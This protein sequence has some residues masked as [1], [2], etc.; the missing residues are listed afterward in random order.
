M[1]MEQAGPAVD[2]AGVDRVGRAAPGAAQCARRDGRDCQGLRQGTL[3]HHGSVGHGTVAARGVHPIALDH[4]L[5]VTQRHV[6]QGA[7]AGRV[8]C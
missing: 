7:I 8:L 4:V 3:R 6:V 1:S 2:V 5:P